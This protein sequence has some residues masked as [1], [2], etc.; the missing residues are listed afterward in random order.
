[1]EVIIYFGGVSY[2][3]YSRDLTFK[4]AMLAGCVPFIPGDILK[5]IVASISA[6]YLYPECEKL[7]LRRE[8]QETEE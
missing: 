6:K 2:L 4:S 1:M 5:I 7:R 3:K 8:K